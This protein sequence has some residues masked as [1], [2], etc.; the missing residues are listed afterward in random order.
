MQVIVD[1]QPI[2]H[3]P[4]NADSPQLHDKHIIIIHYLSSVHVLYH[5]AS[6]DCMSAAELKAYKYI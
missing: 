2:D 4:I 6:K 3:Y 1:A 5:Y